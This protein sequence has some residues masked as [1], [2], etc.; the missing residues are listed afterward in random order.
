MRFEYKILNRQNRNQN[1]FAVNKLT[2]YRIDSVNCQW[3]V[4]CNMADQ[5]KNVRYS[6]HIL[7]PK[8][9]FTRP[10]N[11]M[12]YHSNSCP[13]SFHMN[14]HVGCQRQWKQLLSF[15]VSRT[16]EKRNDFIPS[17]IQKKRPEM[18]LVY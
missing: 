6:D 1:I 7:K 10:H 11:N 4:K 17:C 13:K 2:N 3:L 8:Q 5:S 16:S 15:L 12:N 9:N 14:R 18:M